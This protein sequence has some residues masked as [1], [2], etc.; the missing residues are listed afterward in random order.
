MKKMN[1]VILY[2]GIIILITYSLIG[3]FGY[4]T[5]TDTVHSDLLKSMAA[6]AEGKWYIKAANIL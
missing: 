5:F 4:F 2:N 1:K 6:Q 3:Y